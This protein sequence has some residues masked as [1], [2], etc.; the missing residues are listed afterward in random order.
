MVV[1]TMKSA[2][3]AALLGMISTAGAQTTLT[4]QEAVSR[5]VLKNPE[6]LAR[7]HTFGASKYER[8]AS[9]GGYLPTLDL[10]G[11]V[12]RTHLD[13][14]LSTTASRYSPNNV[15]VILR[16]ML[17]DGFATRSDVKRLDH[18]KR[19]RY[20]ELL[21]TSETAAFEAIRAYQ[22]VLRFQK[23]VEFA[24][25]NYAQHRLVGDQ[26]GERAQKGVSRGVDLDTA[27]GRLAL[28]ESNLVTE[29]SNLYD[30]SARFQRIVGDRPGTLMPSDVRALAAGLPPT[31]IGGLQKAF[32]NSPQLLASMEAIQAAQADV[33]VR[34]STY[35]PRVEARL[36]HDTGREVGGILGRTS[37]TTAEVAFRFNLFNGKRD[38]N[39][40]NQYSELVNLA[41]DVRDRTCR[42]VRQNVLV[43]LND[44]ARLRE[45]LPLLDQHQLATDKAR[46]AFRNQFDLGQRTLLD[47]LDTENEY[48]Q[49][50]RAYIIAE[51]DLATAYARVHASTGGLLAVLGIA[52]IEPTAPPEVEAKGEDIMARCPAEGPDPVVVDKKQA[53]DSAAR[54][55]PRSP[56]PAPA[57]APAGKPKPAP[58]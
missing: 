11:G 27:T 19:V 36:Q 6:V 41:K 34:R 43:A 55:R 42:E 5:A 44:V 8:D 13:D 22:D 47:L 49:S 31:P 33:E 52:P 30:V 35:F 7:Y 17:F 24:A 32:E 29:T 50:R 45:Q 14:P 57:P 4:M 58:R 56:T 48:F 20:Y 38:E 16:Q 21:D 54:L 53:V 12:G 15:S 2:V 26:I 18:A 51:H 3:A 9:W 10:A 46:Q 40:I 1:N 23:L 28:A 39:R 25:D 37:G